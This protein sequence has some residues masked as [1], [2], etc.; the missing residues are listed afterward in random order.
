M[1]AGLCLNQCLQHNAFPRVLLCA[2]SHGAQWWRRQVLPVHEER[3][4]RLGRVSAAWLSH[5]AVDKEVRA[6]QT[7]TGALLTSPDSSCQQNLLD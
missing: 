5:G 2:S 4:P 1:G 3:Q 6:G 7:V